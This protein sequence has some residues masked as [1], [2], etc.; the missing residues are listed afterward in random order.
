MSTFGDFM[1]GQA[2]EKDKELA[3]VLQQ[4]GQMI[5]LLIECRD[6]LPAIS[7]ASAR[8]HGVNLDLADRIEEILKPWEV[9]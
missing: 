8:L 4:R 7:L 5:R 6:A 2:V 3:E 1:I 9:A